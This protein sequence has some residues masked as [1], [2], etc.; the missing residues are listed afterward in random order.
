MAPKATPQITEAM[1]DQLRKDI[2]ENLKPAAEAQDAL[3]AAKDQLAGGS[4]KSIRGLAI[5]LSAFSKASNAKL[6]ADQLDELAEDIVEECYANSTNNSK[7]SQKSKLKT[8]IGQGHNLP[9]ILTG[10]G[11]VFDKIRAKDPKA[12]L[13]HLRDATIKAAGLLRDAEKKEETLTITEA[14]G[15]LK[16][17]KAPPTDED[18]GRT[19]I[20]RARKLRAFTVQVGDERMLDPD[21]EKL[22]NDL[23]GILDGKRPAED[24]RIAEME[25]ELAKFRAFYNTEADAVLVPIPVPVKNEETSEIAVDSP[26]VEPLGG[27]PDGDENSGQPTTSET[28][29]AAT[30]E[31]IGVPEASSTPVVPPKSKSIR[32]KAMSP[33]LAPFAEPGSLLD[34]FT[35]LMNPTPKK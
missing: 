29:V 9:A 18:I 35:N 23:E 11:K 30:D 4:E 26:P 25:G 6:N 8:L 3:S 16:L 21:A 20:E 31:N 24:P 19:H 17:D 12:K 27:T 5:T 10:V 1:L 28:P 13:P 2:I 22:F 7:A 32:E 34:E 33:T 15:Q 14:I